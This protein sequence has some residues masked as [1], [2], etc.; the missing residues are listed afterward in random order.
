MRHCS[1]Y[2]VNIRV[3]N[4]ARYLCVVV[5]QTGLEAILQL[6][7]EVKVYVSYEYKE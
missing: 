1:A 5:S 4:C 6:D 7:K 3:F 2:V